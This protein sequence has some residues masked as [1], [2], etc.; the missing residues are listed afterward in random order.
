MGS[1]Y[2]ITSRNVG[3][4]IDNIIVSSKKLIILSFEPLQKLSKV[5]LKNKNKNY[6][7]FCY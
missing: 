3:K 6:G 4:L 7:L 5:Y 2:L 1:N